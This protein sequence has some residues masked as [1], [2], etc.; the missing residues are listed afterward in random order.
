MKCVN[1]P[2]LENSLQILHP[3]V[4]AAILWIIFLPY[5]ITLH[6]TEALEMVDADRVEE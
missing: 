6:M 4:V 3:F 1:A 2:D 5:V